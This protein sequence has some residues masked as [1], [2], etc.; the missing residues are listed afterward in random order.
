MTSSNTGN[1]LFRLVSAARDLLFDQ[2]ELAQLTY[3]AFNIAATQLESDES[4]EIEVAFPIGRRPDKTTILSTRKYTKA[5]LLGRYQFLALQQMPIN[6]LAQLVTITEALLGDVVRTVIVRHPLKLGAKRTIQLQF[7][8]GAQ[9]LEEVH[10]R[11][12]DTLLNELSYKSPAE[13][14]AS[15]EELLSI[16]LFECPAFHRYIELKATRD[17]HVH[18]RGYV[19]DTYIKKTGSHARAKGGSFL[20]V[21]ISYFLESYESCLQLTEWLE[22]ALDERWH[23]S[24]REAASTVLPPDSPSEESGGVVAER[25]ANTEESKTQK[26]KKKRAPKKKGS[27]N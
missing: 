6:V 13:F 11:A 15:V 12:T 17:I 18:N 4:A 2:G 9:S 24:E 23:S 16:K 27:D 14:A 10:I 22:H 25:L 8:L 1:A 3:G 20:P 21:D 7:V 19:N 5:E 26:P